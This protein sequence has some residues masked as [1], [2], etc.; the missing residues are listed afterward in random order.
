MAEGGS[1]ARI[2][3]RAASVVGAGALSVS[4]GGSGAWLARGPG[5]WAR[6]PPSPVASFR[7]APPRPL[8]AGHGPVRRP[9]PLRS[10]V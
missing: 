2:A 10:P 8:C 4:G 3:R 9:C 7:W 6:A 5:A 1:L